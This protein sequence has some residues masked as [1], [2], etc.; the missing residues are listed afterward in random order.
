MLLPLWNAWH[1]LALYANAENMVGRQRVDSPDLL[2]RYILAKTRDMITGVESALD[3]YGLADA[4]DLVRGFTDALTNWYIRRSR[5]RFW[6]GERDAIDTLH[7]VL[8]LTCRAVAPLLPQ[9]VLPQLPQAVKPV[10]AELHRIG[11]L[12]DPRNVYMYCVACK[13]E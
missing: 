9:P 11:R 6:A 8:E 12:S 4:C 3:R 2:D 10:V 7:T 5:S 13:A 1:F